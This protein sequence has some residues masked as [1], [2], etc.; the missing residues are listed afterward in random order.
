MAPDSSAIEGVGNIWEYMNGDG[1]FEI[2]VTLS[3]NTEGTGGKHAI[4]SE[5]GHWEKCEI[6]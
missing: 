1:E 4:L 2:V 5:D 6:R 3:N